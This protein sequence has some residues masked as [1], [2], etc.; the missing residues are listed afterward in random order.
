[1]AQIGSALPWGGRG[2]GFKSRHSDQARNERI[3]VRFCHCGKDPVWIVQTGFLFCLY[4]NYGTEH[5][6]CYMAKAGSPRSRNHPWLS[7]EVFFFEKVLSA[8]NSAFYPLNSKH[9]LKF[10]PKNVIIILGEF[11]CENQ[12][13]EVIQ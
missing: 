13:K 8:E 4:Y 3:C 5:E 2:R 12:R 10:S 7:R 11:F 9:I 1:M 6:F